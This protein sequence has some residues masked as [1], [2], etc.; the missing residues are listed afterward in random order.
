[1][2]WDRIRIFLEVARTG[3]FLAASKR[4]KLNHA[5]V[6]RQISA[7]EAELDTKLF[8]RRPTGSLLTTSGAALLAAAERAESA[9]L[10]ASSKLTATSK[11][12]SGTVRIG[13]PDGLGNYFLADKLGSFATA[14]P[15]LLVQLVPLPRTFSLTKREADMAITLERPLEGRLISKKLTDYTLSVYAA[16]SYLRKAGE[17]RTR[18]D[19]RRH[20]FITYVHDFMYSRALNYSA[21]F[22]DVATKRF[23]CG[24][25]VGQLEAV[26]A[27][28]GVGILH[29]YAAQ[30]FPTLERILPLE[31]FRRSYW[32]VSH[33]DTY[34]VLRIR[35]V[36]TY[37]TA[38]AKAKR[39]LF[40]H[41]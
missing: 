11:S 33:E 35:A 30:Q 8:E 29:D 31:Q 17:I 26:R 39:R 37:V 27:G 2:N 12:L 4:L 32:I 7:L 20:L 14:N 5:T 16:K 36:R 38:A 15:A 13:A 10:A 21:A 25:A 34:D 28:H 18:D 22:D 19:V 3:Q 41:A 40:V 6:A 1:M 23:E 24:S 9:L